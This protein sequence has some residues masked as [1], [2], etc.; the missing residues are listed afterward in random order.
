MNLD[1]F[2][3]YKGNVDEWAD[4]QSRTLTGLG[5]V[6][7][8]AEDMIQEDAHFV[9]L[10]PGQFQAFC[11]A[12]GQN[13]VFQMRGEVDVDGTIRSVIQKLCEDNE[14]PVLLI[15]T[16][17]V[18][19]ALLLKR[20]RSHCH[21]HFYAEFSVLHQGAFISCGVLCESHDQLM[22]AL[23][24]FCDSADDRREEAKQVRLEQDAETLERLADE[25]LVDPEFAKIRG[26][27]K[28]CV[29]VL[30]KYGDRVPKSARGEIRRV[31]AGDYDGNLA[32]LVERVSDRL[33]L[34]KS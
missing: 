34:S 31:D 32:A 24:A 19:N 20:A 14:D 11:T 16:F 25:L 27:R 8:D 7:I 5:F 15:K 9:F 33:E 4:E 2:G 26:R 17:E 18:Q 3:R 22:E 12:S 28:R 30:E 23:A 1:A 10:E 13:A 6:I 21:E 29:Y